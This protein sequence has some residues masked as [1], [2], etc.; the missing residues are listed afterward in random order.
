MSGDVNT[1]LEVV[2]KAV[3]HDAQ[4]RPGEA[5]YLYDL[6]VSFFNRAMG[7]ETNEGTRQLLS[8]KIRE[9]SLRAV[10]LRRLDPCYTPSLPASTRPALS[11][12]PVQNQN[13]T[14]PP[15]VNTTNVSYANQGDPR[16]I[17]SPS[18]SSFTPV[19][20]THSETNAGMQ[21]V[22]LATN[23]EEAQN[24]QQ[25]LAHWKSAALHFGNALKIESNE[26]TKASLRTRATQCL[27]RIDQ[28]Q[29]ALTPPAPPDPNIQ[30]GIQV[31]QQ[32]TDADSA[33]K[34]PEAIALYQ[35]AIDLLR[36][37]F[38]NPAT[39][40]R[41]KDLLKDKAVYYTMRC[42]QLRNLQAG[43]HNP[44]QLSLA[45]GEKYVNPV[46][47]KGL[48]EKFVDKITSEARISD[49]WSS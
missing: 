18:Q 15:Y 44:V 24:W 2:H 1:G 22:G 32:A 23:A 20:S 41:D 43:N 36:K 17:T 39:P 40:N 42:E 34:I 28:I 26:S 12:E 46:A 7:V 4:G 3:E 27:D 37:A 9:Y 5:A 8:K 47:Q 35:Q 21:D 49:N 11:A 29:A 10:E 16:G 33:G 25:A 30:A 6:A 38:L 19:D 45:P 31:A 13:S 14:M 48:F